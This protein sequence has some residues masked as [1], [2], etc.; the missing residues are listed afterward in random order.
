MA[1]DVSSTA[2]PG[3]QTGD[4]QSVMG[5]P[6]RLRSETA[7]S[8]SPSVLS[9]PS[10][11]EV[12]PLGHLPQLQQGRRNAISG[13]S[14]QQGSEAPTIQAHG[15]DTSNNSHIG[16]HPNPLRSNHFVITEQLARILARE[17]SPPP[18]LP[19]RPWQRR[20]GTRRQR[21]HTWRAPRL[22]PID[23]GLVWNKAPPML[24]PPPPVAPKA[25][26]IGG[27]N[28]VHVTIHYMLCWI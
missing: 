3:E 28:R 6:N 24:R 4:A 18:H 15:S 7:V 25:E 21:L 27:G 1:Q 16:D 26:T 9:A 19:L 22:P 10:Q 17:G 13:P 8:A 5:R 12:H 2:P 14:G 11:D 20:L 23:E